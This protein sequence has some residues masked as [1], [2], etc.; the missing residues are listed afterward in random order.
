MEEVAAGMYNF[1][2]TCTLMQPH[3]RK[4]VKLGSRP[5][6]LSPI[7]KT[8]RTLLLVVGV[9]SS[10]EVCSSW[11]LACAIVE[12]SVSDNILEI[13]FKQFMA[14]RQ[15]PRLQHIASHQLSPVVL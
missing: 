14:P 10:I 8:S 12:H 7:M 4:L 11:G 2:Q 15:F 1:S 5:E 9:S 3:C 6:C 13:V